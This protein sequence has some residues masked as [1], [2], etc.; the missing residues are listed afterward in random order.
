MRDSLQG[1]PRLATWVVRAADIRLALAQFPV[2]V[3]EPV[4]VT[5]GSLSWRIS[6]LV[7]LLSDSR[8]VITR[9]S[10]VRV[11]ATIMTPDGSKEL[12]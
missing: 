8:V 10:G 7:P 1:S 5:R 9:G 12:T 2:V 6:V 4:C 3:G 11:R